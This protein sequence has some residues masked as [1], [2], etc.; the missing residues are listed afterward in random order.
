MVTCLEMLEHVPDSQSVI[1]ACAKLVKPG[2]WGF[3]S[4][5]NRNLKSYLF[6]ILGAEYILNLLPHGTH[7]FDKFIKPS[8]LAQSCRN[9][10]LNVVNIIG[11]SYN[12]L[13]KIYSLGNDTDV[14]Y[15]VACR[16][17]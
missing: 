9:A 10:D 17:D 5:L 6:A 11:M 8:E 2:G 4:T 1:T 12:P 14:N 7:D 15:M 3:F 16:K 13:N